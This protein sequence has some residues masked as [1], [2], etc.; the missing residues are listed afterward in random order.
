MKSNAACKPDEICYND[1]SK[2]SEDNMT[3]LQDKRNAVKL[4]QAQ[5]AAV[6]VENHKLKQQITG[7]SSDDALV[8]KSENSVNT[9]QAT[10]NLLNGK[11]DGLFSRSVHRR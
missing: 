11:S 2:T 6:A 8:A 10:S 5:L 1:D 9:V 4:S 7:D 3:K